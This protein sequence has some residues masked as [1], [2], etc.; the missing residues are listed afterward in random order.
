MV[1]HFSKQYL[2]FPAIINRS[3]E[4][5]TI[6]LTFRMMDSCPLSIY[7]QYLYSSLN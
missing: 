6:G 2:F 1:H 4:M 3:A 7:E 5:E